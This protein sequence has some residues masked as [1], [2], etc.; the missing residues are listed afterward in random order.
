MDK[1]LIGLLAA[2]APSAFADTPQRVLESTSWSLTHLV[3][4]TSDAPVAIADS[5]PSL[6]S[7]LRFQQDDRL[8]A[9]FLPCADYLE[10][11]YQFQSNSTDAA[12]DKENALHITE[13]SAAE[14]QLKSCLGG[15][16]ASDSSSLATAFVGALMNIDSYE[17]KDEGST[18][19]LL[20]DENKVLMEFVSCQSES[21]LAGTSWHPT[22]IFGA[23][24]T[25]HPLDMVDRSL[26]TAHFEHCSISGTS[27]CNS[28]NAY[29]KTIDETD[30]LMLGGMSSTLIGCMDQNL[31]T[32]ET[33]YLGAME[34]VANYKI[35]DNYR[36]MTLLDNAGAELIQFTRCIQ[37]GLMG[38]RWVS[39]AAIGNQAWNT[40]GQQFM[41]SF[42]SDNVVRG[43][44]ICGEDIKIGYT[45]EVQDG[46]MVLSS[47]EE[48]PEVQCDRDN[49]NED[50]Q[51]Q[52][53]VDFE[54]QLQEMLREVRSYKIDGCTDSLVLKDEKG[55]V[56]LSFLPDQDGSF[57]S[58]D[59]QPEEDVP[60]ETEKTPEP[61][62]TET[63]DTTDNLNLEEDELVQSESAA[64]SAWSFGVALV[65]GA[66]TL[67]LN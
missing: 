2:S 3:E 58:V 35:D 64:T 22:T 10:M 50:Y 65:L 16:D 29:Y 23:E 33:A 52:N 61:I 38:I 56:L 24:E 9:S 43:K 44:T 18:L 46:S 4:A 62:P 53:A 30:D 51:H 59:T 54:I 17:L 19:H 42:G 7:V 45:V 11:A 48:W 57:A 26:V 37:M 31:R 49:F 47:E 6:I 60:A 39:N 28:Y 20:D 25:I 8:Q 67:V 66:A 55:N 14:E 41:L 12:T 13:R 1:A 36:K 63:K 34:Q 40:G 32:I 5:D 15:G 21:D 27:A